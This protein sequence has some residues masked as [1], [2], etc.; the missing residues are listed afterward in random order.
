ML[1]IC[2]WYALRWLCGLL[3]FNLSEEKINATQDRQLEYR[4]VLYWLLP[5]TITCPGL[6]RLMGGDLYIAAVASCVLTVV[7]PCLLLATRAMDFIPHILVDLNELKM[8]YAICT[9]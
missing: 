8:F 5:P 7:L 2:G 9:A 3:Y 1:V 6:S 4:W